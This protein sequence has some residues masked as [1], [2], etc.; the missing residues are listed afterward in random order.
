MKEISEKEEQCFQENL[1]VVQ[2]LPEYP[3]AHVH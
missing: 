1:L 2:V 3:F